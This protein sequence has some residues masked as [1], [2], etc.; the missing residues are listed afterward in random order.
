MCPDLTNLHGGIVSCEIC[1]RPYPQYNFPEFNVMNIVPQRN[2]QLNLFLSLCVKR[3]TGCVP[4]STIHPPTRPSYFKVYSI[5][6]KFRHSHF[7]LYTRNISREMIEHCRRDFYIIRHG[8]QLGEFNKNQIFACE[9]KRKKR[10]RCDLI[11]I[12]S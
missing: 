4:L 8:E 7:L 10:K 5:P 2:I 3:R 9:K 1:G 12:N 6:V 11:S